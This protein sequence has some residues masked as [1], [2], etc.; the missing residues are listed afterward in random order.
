MATGKAEAEL[1]GILEEINHCNKCGFCLPSCPTYRLTG[2]E[3]HSPRGRIA[4]VEAAARGELGSL[5]ALEEAL[6]YCVGC[7]NCE[8]ACPSGVHYERILEAGRTYLTRRQRRG[9]PRSF[10]SQQALKL[11]KHPTRFRAIVQLA[12]R[13]TGLPLPGSWA[14]F[15]AMLPPAARAV[16]EAPARQSPPTLGT[17]LF[18]EGCVM[19]ASFEEV[20]RAAKRLLAAAGYTV[21]SLPQQTCCGAIHWHS[22][23]A[24]EARALARQNLQA[25]ARFVE[26][27]E[28]V[29]VVNTAGGCGAML[30]EYPRLL[31]DDPA[32][33]PIAQRLAAMV[34]DFTYYLWGEQGPRLPLVGSR[35]RVTL[36][37]SCHLVNV[38]KGGQ[39]P[40]RLLQAVAGDQYVPF[41]G[42]ELC[43]GSGGVYNLVH[44]DWALG[45]LD[46]KMQA[47]AG[48]HPQRILVN[49]P[50]CHLQLQWGVRR[51]PEV[52][53][54]VEHL[55]TYL[56]RCY[57]RAVAPAQP[58][59]A[60]QISG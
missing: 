41:F 4:L 57:T 28:V 35:E 27:Q 38:A 37:N 12:R 53:A 58:E 51:H 5:G 43:C 1:A 2:Q 25:Y 56:W 16:P 49:N 23:E 46:Q 13:M 31:A 52:G 32:W 24:A 22:G 50:G 33:L 55:A 20:N 59:W 48:V 9:Y 8:T 14:R 40:V 60:E 10:A 17:L 21:V 29:G 15:R 44:T 47:M 42:Q 26:R 6:T 18:F 11:A 54:E 3:L 39:E 34:H 19:T 45:M 7:R 30:T 36:Q